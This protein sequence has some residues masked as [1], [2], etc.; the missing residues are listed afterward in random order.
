MIVQ[1]AHQIALSERT[2]SDARPATDV[3]PASHRPA[4]MVRSAARRGQ[5]SARRLL[6]ALRSA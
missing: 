3:T 2:L 6:P 4:R 5:R 1:F